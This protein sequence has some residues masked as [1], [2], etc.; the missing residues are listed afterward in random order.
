V[1]EE[2]V[3]VKVSSF[4]HGPWQDSVCIPTQEKKANRNKINDSLTR[5]YGLIMAQS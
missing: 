3:S 5:N 4:D 2:N 1:G